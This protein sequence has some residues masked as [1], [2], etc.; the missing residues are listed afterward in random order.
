VRND[1]PG[2]MYREEFLTYVGIPRKVREDLNCR[3]EELGLET[4][5]QLIQA[6]LD[7]TATPT[8]VVRPGRGRRT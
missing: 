5:G 7:A 1:P 4:D 3:R 8:V 2:A 6:L